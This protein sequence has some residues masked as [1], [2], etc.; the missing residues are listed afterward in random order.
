MVDWIHFV[1]FQFCW[2]VFC[3]FLMTAAASAVSSLA[4]VTK[5][6]AGL[7]ASTYMLAASQL[8]ATTT[9]A[10]IVHDN[11]IWVASTDNASFGPELG[12]ISWKTANALQDDIICTLASMCVVCVFKY[13]RVYIL[14]FRVWGSASSVV[15]VYTE[16]DILFQKKTIQNGKLLS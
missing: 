14:Y 7:R 5:P 12:K 4:P 6:A 10:T 9:V 16:I 3:I 11:C 13:M 1:L 8:P 2:F 15:I